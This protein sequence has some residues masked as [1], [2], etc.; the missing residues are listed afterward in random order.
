M[1]SFAVTPKTVVGFRIDC[2]GRFVLESRGCWVWNVVG[3][4]RSIGEVELV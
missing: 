3:V 1:R 2:S 4:S